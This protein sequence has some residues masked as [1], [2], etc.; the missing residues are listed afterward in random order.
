MNTDAEFDLG[1]TLGGN[2]FGGSEVP[3][4][5]T[6]L[7]AEAWV[8]TDTAW[9]RA[10]RNA[11]L[12]EEQKQE[13]LKDAEVL[14]HVWLYDEE[15]D[16]R[17]AVDASDKFSFY[18]SGRT[19]GTDELLPVYGRDY[20]EAV[21]PNVADDPWACIEAHLDGMSDEGRKA[22]YKAEFEAMKVRGG[23]TADDYYG[24]YGRMVRDD[25][26]GKYAAFK[27][28]EAEV[29]E[30]LGKMDRY[31]A[32]EDVMSAADLDNVRGVVDPK[33]M[34]DAEAVR[35]FMVT[36]VLPLEGLEDAE[37][38]LR[39][40]S[41]LEDELFEC[42]GTDPQRA[43]LV[44][45]ALMG[46]AERLR[47][48]NKVGI[49]DEF[50][51]AV[52]KKV[53]D[54][55]R[56][57]E[58]NAPLVSM[59]PVGHPD[60]G[61]MLPD[62]V[63][64]GQQAE[65]ESRWADYNRRVQARGILREAINKSLEL[66]DNES[67]WKGS[68][69]TAFQMGGDTLPYLVPVF[70]P[71]LGTADVG[72]RGLT[73]GVDAYK[74]GGLTD[75]QA[76]GQAFIDTGVQAAVELLPFSRVGGKG[77][78]AFVRSR[79]GK[80]VAKGKV[81]AISRWA[82]RQ[83]QK[84]LPRA[85]AAEWGAAMIDE[86]VLE[87]VAG[88]L[89]QYGAEHIFDVLG[90][91][92][93]Q[94]KEFAACFG[95]LQQI[96]K[97]DQLAGLA[98]FTAGLTG[99][100]TPAIRQNVRYFAAK[101]VMWEAV[102]LKPGQVD[103]L[104]AIK[105]IDE[106]VQIGRKMV[107][108]GWAQDAE[109]MAARMAEQNAA[110]K[111]RGEVLV[112]TGEGAV[113]LAVENSELAP[114]YR[115]VWAEYVDKGLLPKVEAQK[116]GQFKLTHKDGREYVMSA[117]HADAYLEHAIEVAEDV[118]LKE[119]RTAAERAQ[120][121]NL[122]AEIGQAV[123]V[124][125]GN[126]ALRS[127]AKTSAKSGIEVTDLVAG[128]PG[129]LAKPILAKGQVTLAD[130]KAI[131]EWAL[132]QIR[133]LVEGGASEFD[134]RM[135]RPEAEGMARSLGEWSTF[136]EDFATRERTE[137][138]EE[139]TG[140][141]SVGR[142]RG[143]KAVQFDG[144]EVMGQVIM[145]LKGRVS[146]YG[147]VEDIAESVSDMMLQRRAAVLVEQGKASSLAEAEGMALEELA[148]VVRRAREVVLKADP[149]AAISE[150]KGG[151]DLR[152]S[153]IE[154]LSK[155]SRA[156]FLSSGV[157]PKWMQS[158]TSGLK[159]L[160]GTG[161][162][163]ESVRAAYAEVLRKEPN[164][165]AE[166]EGMLADMG[167]YVQDAMREA[168][169]E[170][171]DIQAWKAA[172]AIVGARAAGP[173]GV[174]GAAVSDVVQ[175]AERAEQE[176]VEAEGK[177]DVLPVR[178]AADVAAEA[179]ERLDEMVP[180]SNAPAAMRGVFVDDKCYY[181]EAGGFWC[182]MIAKD[183][184]R[185]GTEQVKVG[186]KGKHG[187]IQGKELTGSFQQNVGA[188]YVWMRK[189]GEL[190]VISGRHRFAKLMEDEKAVYCNCYVFVEDAEHD[191]KWARIL[192]YENNM[193]DDQADEVTAATYV[194][195]TGLS[196]EVLRERGLLRNH[197]RSKRGVLI[198][199]YAGNELWTRFSNGVIKPKDAEIVVELTRG[200]KD[201]SRVD[202]I[203]GK[204]CMLLAKKKSW[205]YIAGMVQLMARA[206]AKM[207]QG[208]LD[209]G[210][211]FMAD[212]E[213]AAEW[214]EK[215]VQKI[216]AALNVLKDGQSMAKGRKKDEAARLGVHTE[217]EADAEEM[218]RDLEL[219]KKQ[220]EFIGSYPELLQQAELWDGKAEV[221]P[222]GY[223]LET[224][225]KARIEAQLEGEM[226]AEEY[227]EEQAR[228]AAA[229]SV[230]SLF[231]M[232]MYKRDMTPE[233]EAIKAAAVADGTFMKAP[234]GKPSNL[235]ERQ[236]LQV[237]TK[238]FADWFGDWKRAAELTFK[239][240][241]E[242]YRVGRAALDEVKDNGSI[243]NEETGI[244]VEL[245][246][247]QKD[248]AFS[249]NARRKSISNGFTVA[250]HNSVAACLPRVFRHAI[251][252][253]EYNDVENDPNI[254]KIMRFGTPVVIDGKK[255]LAFLTVK[256]S[257]QK[258]KEMGK[259]AVNE[260]VPRLYS[261]ELDEIVRLGG[262][263]KRLEYL[264]QNASSPSSE[265]IVI[266]FNAKVKEYF[267]NV[268]K[269]VDE[270]GEP[271]VMYHGSPVAGIREFEM[272]KAVHGEG[273]FFT[274]SP[275]EALSY[276][277]LDE[278]DFEDWDEFD[279][280]ATE[281]GLL[282]EAF[283]NIRDRDRL[284]ERSG[285]AWHARAIAPNEIKSAT[286]NRGTFDGSNPDITF[287]MDRNLAAVHSLS[288]DKF[289]GALELG[290]MPLP[291][292]AVTRLD[293]PYSWGS[294]KHI[295]LVGRPELVDPKRGT[296]VYS[297]DA[298]TGNIPHLLHNAVGKDDRSKACVD[299]QA[300]SEKYRL[301]S[302][303]NDYFR[304][305][306]NITLRGAHRDVDKSEM[307]YHLRRPAA[308]A[309]FA[310]QSGYRPRPKMKDA[311]RIHDWLTKEFA[312]KL[313]EYTMLT[314]DEYHEKEREIKEMARKEAE[315]Y[316]GEMNII[317]N[318]PNAEAREKRLNTWVHSAM[319]VFDVYS[320]S[321]LAR[322]L[323]DVKLSGK[324]VLDTEANLKMLAAYADKHKRAYEA[325]LQAKLDAWYSKERYIEGTN[326]LATLE[327]LTSH[328]L[329][330]KA[331]GKEK[332]LAFGAGL[333]RA[334]HA[335]RMGSLADIQERRELLTDSE[336][337]N[338]MK[339]E[340]HELMED[341]REGA[342]AILSR[343]MRSYGFEVR[344]ELMETL[345]NVKGEPTAEKL[346]AAVR[347]MFRGAT[348]LQELLNNAEVIGYGVDALK[349]LRREL[350]DYMEAVPQRAVKMDEWEY[351]VLPLELKK[352]K[353]VMAGLRENG[354]KPRFHDGT[355]EGRRA[356]LAGLVGDSK[357]SFS[358][359][360]QKAATWDKYD[361]RAFK[362][363]DDGLMRAEIDDS[364]A[365]LKLFND[366][367]YGL[368]VDEI[369]RF[370]KSN[371]KAI[372][373][374][375]EAL[376]ERLEFD[377]G[378]EYKRFSAYADAKQEQINKKALQNYE[379]YL[380]ETEEFDRYSEF[381]RFS[382]ELDAKKE[383]INKRLSDAEK[384]VEELE[385]KLI[386]DLDLT[387]YYK[388]LDKFSGELFKSKIRKILCEE[389]APSELAAQVKLLDYNDKT[390]K[391]SDVMIH[392][393]LFEAYPEL[394]DINISFKKLSMSRLAET[395]GKNITFNSQIPRTR[396]D[397]LSTILHETQHVI[398]RIEGFAPGSNPA[399]A[400]LYVTYFR[401]EFHLKRLQGDL[402]NISAYFA[403]LEQLNELTP[404]VE[405][406]LEK[407]KKANAI[408]K[409]ETASFYEKLAPEKDLTNSQIS[410]RDKSKI[411]FSIRDLAPDLA[412]KVHKMVLFISLKDLYTD[413]NL[414]KIE[415]YASYFRE[416]IF[417]Y[418]RKEISELTSLAESSISDFLDLAFAKEE[419]QRL[420]EKFKGLSPGELYDRVAG[421]IEARNV[422][423]RMNMTAEERAATP[424]N[425]TLEYP[426]E[427]IVMPRL[428]S[429]SV[430]G[431]KAATWDKYADRAFKGRDD[432]KLR[433]EIDA[434]GARL[435]TLTGAAAYEYRREVENVPDFWRKRY[436]RWM[437]LDAL[438][439]AVYYSDE[440]PTEEQRAEAAAAAEEYYMLTEEVKDMMEELIERGGAWPSYTQLEA[441]NKQALRMGMVR[442]LAAGKVDE[443]VYE[444]L[445][446][447]SAGEKIYSL[448]D[449]LDFPE[450][451][452]AYPMLKLVPVQFEL[453]GRYN[454]LVTNYA[455][456]AEYSVIKL[457]KPLLENADAFRSTLLHE[458]QHVIQRI[459]GFA[460]GGN[461]EGVYMHMKEELEFNE[462]E[463]KRLAKEL[464]WFSALDYA[465]DY[466]RSARRLLRYPNAWKYNGLRYQYWKASL[467]G[468]DMTRLLV[469][470]IAGR[471]EEMRKVDELET[472]R[473][474][475]VIKEQEYVLPV[476]DFSN[477]A[478]VERGLE[479]LDALKPRR[480]AFRGVAPK[481]DKKYVELMKYNAAAKRILDE[482]E[483]EPYELYR[484][485]AGEIEARNVQARRD[486]TMAERLAR[487][488]NETL[489]YPGEALVTF[490]ME[491]ASLQALDVLRTRADEREGER[492]MNDWQKACEGWAQLHVGGDDSR[493]GNGA[494]M[495]GEIYALI[496]ATKGVL[497]EKYARMGHLNGLLRW[498]AVYANMQQ[499]GEVP[500]EGVI[501][502][503]IYE[504]FVERM[505][506]LDKKN[507]A[508]GL[509][510][511]EVKE[512]MAL[513]AGERLDVAMLKVAR[514]CKR[515]LE[516]FLK[517]RERER[518][519]WVVERAYPKREK[520]KR[521]PRGKMDAE[522]Y[523][524]M[525]RAYRLMEM[526]AN[527]VAGLMNRIKAALENMETAPADA[528]E[529]LRSVRGGD[530]PGVDEVEALEAELEDELFL[531]QT[532]G[533]WE[534]MAFEQ[535]RRASGAMAELVLLG[536]SAW[537]SK[538]RAERRRAA[539]DR[540]EVSRHF[541][542][543]LEDVQA[544]RGDKTAKEKGR[545]RTSA[546]NLVMGS[547]SYSQLLVALEEKLGKRF[548]GRHMRMIAEAHESIMMENQR[549]HRWMYNT[550][551]DI[552]GLGTEGE[553]EEWMQ[554]NNEVF[555]TG[556]DLELP[557]K[558]TCR[559]TPEAAK[560][561]LSL[562]ADE[563]EKKREELVAEAAK[564]GEKPDN[565]PGEDVMA[566][567]EEKLMEAEQA[568]AMPKEFVFTTEWSYKSRLKCTR[569]AL[570]YA[571]LTF[572]QEDYEHLLEANGLTQ[573]K[574]QQMRKLVGKELLRWG[575]AM[576]KE[577][578]EHG[579]MVAELYE[580][581]TGVPFGQ[582]QNYF[583]G[584]FDVARAKD[585]GEAVDQVS[586]V[587]GG[588][589]GIL[590]ARQ[591]HNQQLN[592]ATSASAVFV[593]T[594]KEQQN[595]IA[596]AHIGREWRTLLSDRLFERRVRAEI[597]DAALDMLT[598]WM[599]MIE[600]AVLADAKV[601]TMMNNMLGKLAKAYAVSR[602][603]G[604]A[605]T[606]MKQASALLNGFVGGYV[607][608]RVLA[609]NELVQE[610]TY[611]HVG[612]GEYMAAL[613]KAMA[614]KTEI[615]MKE[616]E[617]AGFIAGRKNVE[618][619]HV[620]EAAL[621]SSWQKVPGKVGRK[622]RAL[623]E[624]NMDAI[625]YVDRKANARAALAIAEVVYQQA[626]KENAD[627]LVPDAELRRVALETARMMVDRA[628]QPQLRTQKGYLAA[629]G[630]AFGALGNFF[631]MFK[632]E[633]L[634]KIGLYVAQM[635]SGQHRA[636]IVG[637]LSFGV[638]NS[639]ILALIDWICGRWYDDD[640]DKWE[641]RAKSFA[642]NVLFNDIS[643]VPLL[644]ELPD[645]LRGKLVGER[646]WASNSLVSWG[647]D[648]WKY[649][650]REWKN[651]EEG[652]SWDKH[653]TALCGLT[654]SVGALGGV[655]LNGHNAV[656]G[657]CCELAL[658]AASLSNT[659]RFLKD[660]GKKVVGE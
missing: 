385:D 339:D 61:F 25:V 285:G 557:M 445:G 206:E 582:R 602:L 431:Q 42:I 69:R 606:I 376:K 195:E 178:S 112:M 568:D 243:R 226:T 430:I 190:Q 525:E 594:M 357:V 334:H 607:P 358:V 439:D 569:E 276:T 167:V 432:G 170:A 130:A 586:G 189:N 429:F 99:V 252:L 514:E 312:E 367:D 15:A 584:V 471:Y 566:E 163:V 82:V 549:R 373:D 72:V 71:A 122:R 272:H 591:Y 419:Q 424:F 126:A 262:Q 466:L 513:L 592:W 154:A 283:L 531:A 394:K 544:E 389:K 481:K 571:I 138:L 650:A 573:A 369:E 659:V 301:R 210:A 406:I 136:A 646:Y 309:L 310:W 86:A 94:T 233:M 448:E 43:G 280:Y 169:I 640:D 377:W 506:Y 410:F 630:G 68:L 159:G 24:L 89:L 405:E 644:G 496:G 516:M 402:E 9:A 29:Q 258:R 85:M 335:E 302:D 129:S 39:T 198:G 658:A 507:E 643:T 603:A 318:A 174:G 472:K 73:E 212:L 263:L 158:L 247:T 273:A 184:L 492:L 225:R 290:G 270:N 408:N 467:D 319:R 578:S 550:L 517:D 436:A 451:Y 22:Q 556:I 545:K 459:E 495:L 296:E 391:L 131:S 577:L 572:E 117:A 3:E 634:N 8:D 642:G 605:Y 524:R 51:V 151:K 479:A 110:I 236:W 77:L 20:A 144:R 196:D 435:K 400:H 518:I 145:G 390:F 540:D 242:D 387:S 593:A 209:F 589:Y 124:I 421:E 208:L 536:R 177:Q 353:A 199:R 596:T 460:K 66:G 657:S 457:N 48:S 629:G 503:P 626:K 344:D 635:M 502:G 1:V 216:N 342:A 116:D 93:G 121:V 595:Y 348:N 142:Y 259:P 504:K 465:K 55:G 346:R 654:R 217:T 134:A 28:R 399:S 437:E 35:G 60:S 463:M 543:K 4:G 316:Y 201:V 137:G 508:Y 468:A 617:A 246:R 450:L 92:H 324:R 275:E 326:T 53:Q 462:W 70:G 530:V 6:G 454:G 205:E 388:S 166:L 268:S 278:Y 100:S 632:S 538:L 266:N 197:S 484:R 625:G 244:V 403:Y 313:R 480:S 14:H 254:A 123:S 90:L 317:K 561:W 97:P 102:G 314:P 267:D 224:A 305:E 11:E 509:N 600:G 420:E 511:A 235:N 264:Q 647:T 622:G 7:M 257:Y 228:K 636:W 143:Q 438:F 87:P 219:L 95:E 46:F 229:E 539:F 398:Q 619:S 281:S 18:G 306:E 378:L 345:A 441:A 321:V 218:L 359:I 384:V 193:R 555:D 286:D 125:A 579:K 562:S 80:E 645:W 304:L 175:E 416:G 341:W 234:N 456:G 220:F 477:L 500:A 245:N 548:T 601:N 107:D 499:T 637:A 248:K 250:Q 581:Y 329:G 50:V 563:R 620:E 333:V 156:K 618:G 515:R 176:I 103:E 360:G 449:V 422:Q 185:D 260:E 292:V 483:M 200:I 411:D 49:D 294:E 32:G 428:S 613:G 609:G 407:A 115:A 590:I 227:L 300:I 58:V 478:G 40:L 119:A 152:M 343:G 396:E 162:A 140:A 374:Y 352:N 443:A 386:S 475:H 265:E 434:S 74:L 624:A 427:A 79:F 328:M 149:K 628:A 182:G 552:T 287:S 284:Y 363:R 214:I 621:L 274:D 614:G 83:T 649:G 291:S 186:A 164:A 88:G 612:F 31:V 207:S 282:Y 26:R 553:I 173:Q 67:W 288:A 5:V 565:I 655:G 64:R 44:Y 570:L 101:R 153:V 417:K 627:G 75:A 528:V 372:H 307:E 610:L 491:R 109:G 458:V 638:M 585:A 139:G 277:G 215:S 498:A 37:V 332:G 639:V 127:V 45:D 425:S 340:T 576:R 488:F 171:V 62:D 147:A 194:R 533:C 295:Y 444:K 653:V 473:R 532:F 330:E 497:P 256:V 223:Y 133:A 54:W 656:I 349:S 59:A 141:V 616:V 19:R 489:E 652:A 187:V 30:S 366:N 293:K 598:G 150:V 401:K 76:G 222:I 546:K 118:M 65:F 23:D 114:A 512:A 365:R 56:V 415:Q 379:E 311:V 204:C 414:P 641:K 470:D 505:R 168:R 397:I 537:Q 554:K 202:E 519:D 323:D 33:L 111:E 623:Y 155:M 191:E 521:S 325:W 423:S 232:E 203:Q 354:I 542:T 380:K 461:V 12:R 128:L 81:G 241:V 338:E 362:G 108:D 132:G 36:Y 91:E 255:A 494:K 38:I 547:M 382:A 57:M 27:Q 426:G 96:W 337:S 392:H 588:K 41:Q 113:D 135:T 165:L 455:Y 633:T 10:K 351:A 251:L 355:E 526:E 347:K 237:R 231:S 192:D 551:R 21:M 608:E 464:R 541:G 446:A 501:K 47:Q 493:L 442:S 239:G 16:S 476:V 520:G 587:T 78:S 381:K 534:N 120:G 308:Q 383:Q 104:M 34:A 611:R 211:D 580:A 230:P 157:V 188:I 84:S 240:D 574:L 183:K 440:E 583:R 412:E 17:A 413:E 361:D 356:A 535:A 172:S 13:R 299:L 146:H 560:M 106:R 469:D 375:K 180:G 453:L 350:E 105:D 249:P 315:A 648:T 368:I 370:I 279:S 599:K 269:V 179:K 303:Y 447:L 298:W 393:E 660:V 322:E 395:D 148:D 213:K 510:D 559:L 527:D 161:A 2:V 529:V 604:N 238:A 575:Y 564:K 181:N 651:I 52:G 486:W 418:L 63:Y 297:R 452:E 320:P 597:G 253:G 490:S 567:L 327:N 261:L 474:G 631:Y 98:L 433:A 615:T 221:D 271:K 522:T 336:S 487:P 482:Y 331:R 485:L 160:L 409:S 558:S 289:L 371:K 523:R 364:Q 404:L